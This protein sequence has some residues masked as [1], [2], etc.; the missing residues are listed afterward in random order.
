[1]ADLCRQCMLEIYGPET[2]DNEGDL[3]GVT[4]PEEWRRGIA[5]V[6]ICEGCGPTLVDDKG[7]CVHKGCDKAGHH[8]RWPVL[9]VIKRLG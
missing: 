1:M 6:A 2:A 3:V 4:T 9:K 7:N 5:N 8:V